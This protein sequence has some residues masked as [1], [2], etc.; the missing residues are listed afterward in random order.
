MLSIYCNKKNK[1]SDHEEEELEVTSAPLHHSYKDY[2]FIT[3]VSNSMIFFFSK[4]S[5]NQSLISASSSESRF[6]FPLD[7][8][9]YVYI[10]KRTRSNDVLWCKF[11]FGWRGRKTVK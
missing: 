3:S 4:N 11:V 2:E 5:R 6:S 7:L 1:W 9:I 10:Y 8:Y